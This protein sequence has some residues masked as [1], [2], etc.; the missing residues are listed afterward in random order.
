MRISNISE[1]AGGADDVVAIQIVHGS[2]IKWLLTLTGA[3]NTTIPTADL[4]FEFDIVAATGTITPGSRGAF[5]LSNLSLVDA[6]NVR[7]RDELV[8]KHG[9]S[10]VA[11]IA[12]DPAAVPP[13]VASEGT[14]STLE[15]NQVQLYLP[16]HPSSGADAIYEPTG[17]DMSA[18]IA[19]D[20]DASV[21]IVVGTLR[22]SDGAAQ[23]V[24]R[25][26][27]V[28]IVIRYGVVAS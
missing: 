5:T 14:S 27:R 11:G 26:I 1:F 2:A 3:N 17:D 15:A 4:D 28:I 7:S 22:Y 12:A 13:V 24:I 18:A 20:S 6:S 9:T 25:S 23:P 8:T 19:F 21:P 16:T 10:D